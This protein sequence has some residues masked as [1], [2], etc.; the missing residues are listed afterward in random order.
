M[1]DEEDGSKE[2]GKESLTF[3]HGKASTSHELGDPPKTNPRDENTKENKGIYTPL[4]LG[5]KSSMTDFHDESSEEDGDKRDTKVRYRTAILRPKALTFDHCSESTD[6]STSEEGSTEE[7]STD[8]EETVN[9]EEN[10]DD[11]ESTDEEEMIDEEQYTEL[12]LSNDDDPI[13][14]GGGYW[15]P[16]HT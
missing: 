7:E 4:V 5:S 2:A 8:E 6:E 15:H 12:E 9:D 10:A 14:L 1:I 13:G 3:H 16:D 11:G